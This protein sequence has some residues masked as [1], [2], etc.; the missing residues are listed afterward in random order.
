MKWDAEIR[1]PEKNLFFLLWNLFNPV[2]TFAETF[3]HNQG[4]CDVSDPSVCVQW[5]L[6]NYISSDGGP[7]TTGGK[8][9]PSPKMHGP[10]LS[11]PSTVQRWVSI[12]KHLFSLFLNLSVGLQ[13]LLPHSSLPSTDP[14]HPSLITSTPLP[15]SLFE[16]TSLFPFLVHRGG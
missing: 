9:G 7:P 13:H 6:N 8:S 16:T 11:N 4:K 3:N 1:Q 2:V 15:P 14:R 10:R 5:S 12:V